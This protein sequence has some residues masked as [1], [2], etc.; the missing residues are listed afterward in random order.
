MK[1]WQRYLLFQLPGLALVATLLAAA[2]HW[3]SLPV[4][5]CVLGMTVWLV[6]DVAL[7]PALKRSYRTGGPTGPESMVGA[8]G[9]ANDDLRPSGFVRIGLELWRAES[10]V[11]I[12]AGEDVR[13]A[14]CVGMT[15][16]VDPVRPPATGGPD[17][18]AERAAD[19]DGAAPS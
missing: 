18:P 10:T 8:L 3:L 17:E 5:A 6:K 7:Y 15:L 16:L 11:P 13:V 14:G 2:A 12:E 4:W 1:T 19:L 9:T